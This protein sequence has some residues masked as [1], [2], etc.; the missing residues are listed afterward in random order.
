MSLVYPKAARVRQRREFQRIRRWGKR[1]SGQCVVVEVL[2]TSHANTR[3]GVTVTKRFGNACIR[4][5]FKRIVREG[6]RQCQ[7]LLPV[8]LD[9]NV[10]PRSR[11]RLAKSQDVE[12]DLLSLL[13]RED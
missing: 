13:L 2:S 1:L 4:S 10:R 6:F 5:R 8:G 9:L 12:S 11:G 7:H 3:L